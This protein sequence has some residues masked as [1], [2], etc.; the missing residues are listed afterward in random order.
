[1]RRKY[2]LEWGDLNSGLGSD[3]CCVILGNYL[4]S[5]CLLSSFHDEDFGLN[6]NFLRLKLPLPHTSEF[7]LLWWDAACQ[8]GAELSLLT[9]PPL[10]LIPSTLASS[11]SSGSPVSIRGVPSHSIGGCIL[12][13]SAWLVVYKMRGWPCFSYLVNICNLPSFNSHFLAISLLTFHNYFHAPLGS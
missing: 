11:T 8:P 7:T 3:T 4:S 5:L 10:A 12:D 6:S 13:H 9:A 2:N 1:M